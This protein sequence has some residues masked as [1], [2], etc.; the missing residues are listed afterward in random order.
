VQFAQQQYFNPP[1]VAIKELKFP[2]KVGSLDPYFI[3]VIGNVSTSRFRSNKREANL[4]IKPRYP[5]FGGWNYPF[6][7]GWNADLKNFLRK[8]STGQ[9]YILNVPFLEGP[10]QPEGMEY[11][12]IELR[13]ILPEGAEYVV[14]LSQIEFLLT[15]SRNVQYSTTVPLVS[16]ETS[17]HRTFMDT[18]GRT[19]LTLTAINIVDNFRERELIVTYDYPL[20]AGL[21]KPLVIFVTFFGL[22]VTAWAIGSLDVGI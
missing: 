1:S 20:L 9:G 13:V 5:V 10:K 3:D 21:R 2:L 8:L 12:H 17:L 7:V 15:L 6:R 4:E 14:L 19:A 11:E 22:F 16:V 18:T